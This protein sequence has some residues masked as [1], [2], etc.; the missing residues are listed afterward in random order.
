MNCLL[1]SLSEVDT[2]ETEVIFLH[3]LL[4]YLFRVFFLFFM[5]TWLTHVPVLLSAE[6][7]LSRL[8]VMYTHVFARIQVH[9]LRLDITKCTT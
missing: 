4:F 5:H 8:K 1:F 9:R 6:S 3:S 2:Q 7:S